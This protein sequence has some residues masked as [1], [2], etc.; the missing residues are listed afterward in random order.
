MMFMVLLWYNMCQHY[1]LVT[2][3]IT[4]I[5]CVC[6]C[7]YSLHRKIVIWLHPGPLYWECSNWSCTT[8]NA[9]MTSYYHL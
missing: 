6:V 3:V 1:V 9:V 5:E 7:G 8:S 4:Y 2:M